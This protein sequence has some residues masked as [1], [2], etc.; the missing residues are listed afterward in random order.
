[1]VNNRRNTVLSWRWKDKGGKRVGFSFTFV[2]FRKLSVGVCPQEVIERRV[3]PMRCHESFTEDLFG[4]VNS[5][6]K[7]SCSKTFPSRTSADSQW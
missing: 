4:E 5:M 3:D 7:T 1:M 6:S 2:L